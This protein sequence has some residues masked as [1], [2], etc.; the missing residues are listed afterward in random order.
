MAKHRLHQLKQGEI[1][2]HEYNEEYTKLLEHTYS[3]QPND[4]ATFT[5]ISSY[6]QGITNPY[7]RTARVSALKEIFTF[8]LE[9]D[10][11]HKIRVLDFETKPEQIYPKAINA[12]K[13]ST[14]YKCGK[15]GHFTKEC[16]QNHQQP[17]PH[18]KH[19]YTPQQNS[20]HTQRM[21][22]PP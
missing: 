10:Q 6:I 21:H 2:I 16:P 12:V 8:S 17:L 20:Q 7:V 3:L 1:A 11:T 19:R 4:S 13:N 18:H 9:K 22:L 5:L 15:E 14:Y